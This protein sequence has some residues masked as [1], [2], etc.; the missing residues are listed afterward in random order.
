MLL[1]K[2]DLLGYVGSTGN[3]SPDVRGRVKP[4]RPRGT[5]N[6]ACAIPRGLIA[7]VTARSSQRLVDFDADAADRIRF[8]H[9]VDFPALPD[10]HEVQV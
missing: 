2:G 7:C 6:S 8:D 9:S 3:A 4:T 10:H 5:A 1:W